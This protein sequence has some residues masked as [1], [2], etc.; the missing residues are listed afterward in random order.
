MI[1]IRHTID[2]K[3]NSNKWCHIWYDIII[4][5]VNLDVTLNMRDNIGD[6]AFD[7]SDNIWN[8]VSYDIY[9]GLG[10]MDD[11]SGIWHDIYS[12]SIDVPV[13]TQTKQAIVQQIKQQ[14]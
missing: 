2:D 10:F 7:M 1:N 11:G 13:S 12:N 14:I 5:S 9:C 4:K 8:K 3:I 6:F